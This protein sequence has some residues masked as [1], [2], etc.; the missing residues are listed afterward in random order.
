MNH[1]KKLYGQFGGI[2]FA[3]FILSN[4]LMIGGYYALT[5][6]L[7][8]E[9]VWA[10]AIMAGAAVLVAVVAMTIGRYYV[11]Q[12]IRAAW[13]AVLHVSKTSADAPAPKVDQLAV[14]RQLVSALCMMVYDFASSAPSQASAN[15]REQTIGAFAH[16]VLSKFPQPIIIFNKEGQA[17]YS[18]EAAAVYCRLEEPIGKDINTL[19]HLTYASTDTID[20]WLTS[21]RANRLTDNHSWEHVK[22]RVSG[23]EPKLCDIA[24]H[25]NKDNPLGFETVIT[26]FDKTNS[27]SNEETGFSYIALAVHELRTPLTIMRGYIEVFEE[28]LG[29]QLT[30]ELQDFMRKLNASAQQ[31]TAFISNILNV[32]RIDEGQFQPKIQKENWNEL[33]PAICKELELRASLRGKRLEYNIQS[34]LPA[35]GVDRLSIYEVIA[36]LVD[37]AIKYSPNSN[38]IV[39]S[40]KRGKEGEVETSVQDFGIGMPENILQHLFTKF[41]RNH[42]SKSQVAG[43]GL[44]LFLVKSIVTAHGGNVWV[45][46]KEG[47]G[48]TFSFSLQTYDSLTEELKAAGDQR[49]ITNQTHGWIKNHS[50][51]R[52]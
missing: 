44:G 32:A 36:N 42:R 18:N 19:L 40:A 17:V 46:S 3:L 35:V 7:E 9:A 10:L 8:L 33:L 21:A 37:N 16:A 4:A 34:D 23:Q 48:T 25:F 39:I 13:Q 47:E 51:Q 43:S 12:P 27:Y 11:V 38:R 15:D 28:E 49:A 31:L 24:A 14:G 50:L 1:F 26:L 52:R 22:L 45:N 20:S 41:Y 6:V 5:Q 29:T 2:L 30:P